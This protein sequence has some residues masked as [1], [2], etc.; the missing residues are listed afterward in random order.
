[1]RKLV[2]YL[3]PTWIVAFLL[4]NALDHLVKRVGPAVAAPIP[5]QPRGTPA[6]PSSPRRTLGVL[7]QGDFRSLFLLIVS[8]LHGNIFIAL[9]ERVISQVGAP[10]GGIF[11][12]TTVLYYVL[13]FRILQS[14]LAAAMKYDSAWRVSP[15]DFVVV[16]LTAIFEYVLFTHD[17]FAWASD[18]FR[19]Q[20]LLAF[21]FFGAASYLFTY[22]RTR[23]EMGRA[24]RTSE[25]IIQIL[26]TGFMLVAAASIVLAMLRPDLLGMHALNIWLSVLLLA[27]IYVS[28]RLT[29]RLVQ[30]G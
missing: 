27:N 8:L 6:V 29:L 9:T 2:R 30:G 23:G 14:Q 28:M 25:R 22:M 26:N 10:N 7:S 4:K 5:F 15:F 12:T 20:L 11:W 19:L 13:F 17:R 21:S 16:F 1:M 24:E 3:V 18:T